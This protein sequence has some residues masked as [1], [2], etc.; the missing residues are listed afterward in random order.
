M[1]S[2]EK[3]S[4]IFLC[5]M[6]LCFTAMAVADIVANNGANLKDIL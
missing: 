3:W 5:V 1:D 6:M 4:F 2:Y